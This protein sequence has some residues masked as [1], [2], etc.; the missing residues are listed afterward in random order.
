MMASKNSPLNNTSLDLEKEVIKRFRGLASFISP[1]CRVFRE[2]NDR[3]TVLCLDWADCP[4]D[5]NRRKQEWEKEVIWLAILC[6]YLGIA[7][8]VVWKNGER[9]VGWMSLEEIA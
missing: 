6:D 1:Q 3:E 9:I 2:L 7:K 5:L 8:N 4:Q